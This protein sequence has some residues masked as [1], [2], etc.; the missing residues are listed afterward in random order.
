MESSIELFYHKDKGNIYTSFIFMDKNYQIENDSIK[1]K[2]KNELFNREPLISEIK[3][4]NKEENISNSFLF[5]LYKGENIGHLILN[6]FFKES[7]NT[8]ELIFKKEEKLIIKFGETEINNFDTFGNKLRKR[9]LLIN[10]VNSQ[11]K[12]N[13]TNIIFYIYLQAFENDYCHNFQLSFYS[14]TKKLISVKKIEENKKE[15]NLSFNTNLLK[16][17]LDDLNNFIDKEDEK[18]ILDETSVIQKYK[19]LKDEE[20]IRLNLSKEELLKLFNKNEYFNIYY[21]KR[22]GNI[23]YIK[24]KKNL[25]YIKGLISYLEDIKTIISNDNSLKIYQK[26]FILEFYCSMLEKYDFQLMK[27]MKIKYYIMDNVEKYSVFY[28]ILNFFNEFINQLNESS[29][30]FFPLLELNSGVGFY[31]Q[32]KV[33]CFNMININILKKH[34]KEII[35]EVIISFS[36]NVNQI[37]L[38]QKYNGMIS[39]NTQKI[40]IKE[41]NLDFF[42]KKS[43]DIHQTKNY[44]IKLIRYFFHEIAHKKFTFENQ[45]KEFNSPVKFINKNNEIIT[46]KYINSKEKGSNL[47]KILTSSKNNIGDSGHFLEYYFGFLLNENIMDLFVKCPDLSKLIDNPQLFTSNDLTILKKYIKYKY[48]TEKNNI[49]YNF[50]ENL[51]ILDEVT[52][53]EELIIKNNINPNYNNYEE[54]YLNKKRNKEVNENEFEEV[55][56][57]INFDDKESNIKSDEEYKDKE[58]EKDEEFDKES[59]EEENISLEELLIKL[60]DDNLPFEKEEKYRRILWSYKFVE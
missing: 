28:Y 15:I 1:I 23:I 38:T 57:K 3:L 16:N 22:L 55:K 44:A 4:Y 24:K 60:K 54:K 45:D 17:F 41:E 6:Y 46:L 56:R 51:S 36:L 8:Y 59:S 13:D 42:M 14:V 34:L 30:L 31:H 27:T 35:P 11:I 20:L 12:I 47:C 9:C 49:I 39:F 48:I 25:L 53:L 33:Y 5:N 18:I 19:K 52:K 29:Y 40:G 58:M 7:G 50:D 37:A 10:Y 43:I 26:V 21:L 2:I 32:D